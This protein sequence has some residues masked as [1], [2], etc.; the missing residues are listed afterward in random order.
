[1][2]ESREQAAQLLALRLAAYRGRSPLVLGIPRG[3]VVMA[4][5][6]AREL[7][8]E[9]DVALVHKLRAPRQPE[10][11]I[12]AVDEA[13]NISLEP[14]AAEAGAN[15]RYLAA[16]RD[17]QLAALRLRRAAYTPGRGA[18]DPRERVLIVVDD[19]IATG[20]TM[21]AALRSLREKG[22]ER[23]VAAAAVASAEAVTRLRRLADEVAVL[24]VPDELDAVSLWFERFPQVDD[25]EVVTLLRESVADP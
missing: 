18:I 4:C 12:G 24:E 11:A 13:G 23:L 16:E 19:G 8:G 15:D 22:P 5:I 9:V 17:Q 14:F 6:I 21:A 25:A 1:V 7:G 3:A 2:F 10:L 20:A